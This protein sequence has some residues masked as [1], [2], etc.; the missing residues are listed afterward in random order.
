LLKA[1]LLSSRK[2]WSLIFPIL[3]VLF[4]FLFLFLSFLLEALSAEH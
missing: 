3:L 4:L 1:N 2:M